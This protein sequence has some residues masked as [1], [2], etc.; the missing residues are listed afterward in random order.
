MTSSC[1]STLALSALLT[2]TNLPPPSDVHVARDAHGRIARS[3]NVL[4]V[5]KSTHPCPA[6]GRTNGAC[7]GFDVSHAWPLSCGGPD[8]PENLSW[9]PHR[10]HV[11]FHRNL[12]TCDD[13]VPQP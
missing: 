6:N 1:L 13:A 11:E 4:R 3:R 10:D 12:H 2:A 8:S 5:W 7:P 9:L